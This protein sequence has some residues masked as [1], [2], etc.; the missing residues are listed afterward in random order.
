M[1]DADLKFYDGLGNDHFFLLADWRKEVH[2]QG[3][4]LNAFI[5]RQ[6]GM[7]PLAALDC[8]CG[9]G[10]R[11]IGLA[12]YG[13]QIHA[14][15]ANPAAIARARKEAAAFGVAVNF[16]VADL[17][18]LN[19][20]VAGKFDLVLAGEEALSP[21]ETDA[22]LLLAARQMRTRLW[23]N[24]LLL[25]GIR[26]DAQAV[27]TAATLPRVLETDEGRRIVFQLRDWAEDRRRYMLNHFFL[28]QKQHEWQTHLLTTQHRAWQREELTTILHA[29]GFVDI[30]WHTPA[31]SGFYQPFVTARKK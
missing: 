19:A 18:S 26:D 13:Y 30:V 20:V 28:Q 2:R 6:L 29:A 11:A 9:I 4:A 5:R 21:L 10:A 12:L 14:T 16:E 15:D 23:R 25:I 22:E 24:G 17:R 7:R 31:E 27:Q 1:Q 8:S 3:E